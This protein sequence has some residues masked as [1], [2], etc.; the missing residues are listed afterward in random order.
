MT[1]WDREKVVMR[2]SQK[3]LP[4]LGLTKFLLPQLMTKSLLHDWA[5]ISNIPEAVRALI[6]WPNNCP[7]QNRNFHIEICYSYLRKKPTLKTISH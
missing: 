3:C 2:Y 5:G 7:S 6:I 1:V 4:T